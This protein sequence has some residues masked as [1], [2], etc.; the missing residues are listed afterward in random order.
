[1]LENGKSTLRLDKLL[2]VMTALDLQFRL[3]R[4]SG[5]IQTGSQG[6]VRPRMRQS[7]KGPPE[8]FL[9]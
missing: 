8:D 5:G 2:D 4:G 3:E 7:P 9:D 6:S 1:M